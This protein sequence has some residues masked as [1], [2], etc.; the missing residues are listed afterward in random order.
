MH[1][2]VLAWDTADSRPQYPQTIRL[3]G[4]PDFVT[5]PSVKIW[6]ARGQELEDAQKIEIR[7]PAEHIG[8][9]YCS[10]LCC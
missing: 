1:S 6:S 8:E 5:V 7:I 3:S 10:A 9:L 2:R 4:S